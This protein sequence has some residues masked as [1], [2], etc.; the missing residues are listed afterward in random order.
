MFI[1]FMP[2]RGRSP[3]LQ[4][5][6]GCALTFARQR[7]KL[8]R[9]LMPDKLM[10]WGMLP[11]PPANRALRPGPRLLTTFGEAISEIEMFIQNLGAN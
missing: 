7:R 6:L 11:Q 4:V 3:A 1:R 10:D 5:C 9:T 2:E 8:K